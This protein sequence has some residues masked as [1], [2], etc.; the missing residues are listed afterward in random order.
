MIKEA[1]KKKKKNLLNTKGREYLVG[2]N[3]AAGH[4][5]FGAFYFFIAI[6]QAKR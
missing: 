6:T 4:G 1:T 5:A 3:F 2:K